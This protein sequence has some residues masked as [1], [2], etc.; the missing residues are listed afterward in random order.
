MEKKDK[1]KGILIADSAGFIGSHLCETGV[2]R[3]TINEWHD[4]EFLSYQK[5]KEIQKSKLI[6]SIEQARRS[7]FYKEKLKDYEVDG[8][9]DIQNLPLTFKDELRQNDPHDFISVPFNEI[10]R[11]FCSSGTTGKPT[12]SF[13]TQ[14][15][16]F[17]VEEMAFRAVSRMELSSS[18]FCVINAPFELGMPGYAMSRMIHYANAGQ[19]AVGIHSLTPLQQ[20]SLI[21]ELRVNTYFGYVSG[22]ISLIET[23]YE[24]GKIDILRQLK[25]VV[26]AAEPLSTARAKQIS[27]I[28]GCKVYNNYGMSEIGGPLGNDCIFACGMHLVMDHIFW[29]ILD[30]LTKSPSSSNEGVLVL[31]TLSKE[32]S[33]LI[34]YWTN[35]YVKIEYGKCR[36]GREL[37]RIFIKDKL[38]FMVK[39]KNKF[40][41]ATDIEE[42]L[43]HEDYA[44]MEY[45]AIVK[46]SDKSPKLSIKMEVKG[47]PPNVRKR[48]LK[49]KLEEKLEC[50]VDIEFCTPLSLPRRYPKRIRLID[51]RGDKK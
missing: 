34:R 22:I 14:N 20:L 17:V 32:A 26:V 35:D 33:P 47:E 6:K 7:K 43:L 1:I 4:K 12:Y 51:K 5:L 21:K 2:G 3:V 29:E 30:P 31:T 9:E 24:K 16:L 23:A 19:I 45:L 40:I 42:I 8:T 38:D 25:T 48:E 44:W 37:P 41:S 15:D 28:L 36:C 11:V 27:N 39:L 10:K 18:N 50:D 49:E 46:G 13:F